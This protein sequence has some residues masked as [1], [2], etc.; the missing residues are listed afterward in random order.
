MT[1]VTYEIDSEDRLRHV[2]E[3]WSS[4]A[5][6]NDASHLA[7][8]A[9]IG[10]RIWDSIAGSDVRHVYSLV[11]Q[12]VRSTNTSAVFP[13][14]CDSPKIR[15]FMELAVSPLPGSALVFEARLLRAEERPSVDL[16]DPSSPRSDE[17]V[18]VCSWCKRARTP[19]DRWCEI[20]EA[21]PALGLFDRRPP[22]ITHTICPDCEAEVVRSD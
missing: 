14:R 22:S 18:T 3:V 5:L 11:F 10:T 20:G 2:G 17:L 1:T 8:D 16:L 13:F 9:T 4:F 7:H 15:R 12:R 6:A 19:E 21:I